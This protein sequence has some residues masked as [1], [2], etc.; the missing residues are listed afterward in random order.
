MKSSIVQ[1][2]PSENIYEIYYRLKQ[3]GG[4]KV[5]HYW[6]GEPTVK[7]TFKLEFRSNKKIRHYILW[8]KKKKRIKSF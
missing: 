6:Q 2:N 5:P 8:P 3:N 1:A 4:R 7:R